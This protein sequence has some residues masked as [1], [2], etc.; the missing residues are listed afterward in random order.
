MARK[1]QRD[2]AMLEA[3]LQA[4]LALNAPGGIA[5]L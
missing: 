4:G 3:K 1:P 5:I 2:K